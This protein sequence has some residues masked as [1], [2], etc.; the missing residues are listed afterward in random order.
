MLCRPIGLLWMTDEKGPDAK[1]LAVPSW[2]VRIPWR[3]LHEV[4]EFMKLE[5][6]H[7]FDIYKQLEPGKRT[8]TL[9][10]DDRE[11]AERE[12]AES[13]ERYARQHRAGDRPATG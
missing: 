8:E 2:D 13:Q 5:I 7:F 9:N 10:W 1:I 11:A 12:I 6:H 3:D 4:P